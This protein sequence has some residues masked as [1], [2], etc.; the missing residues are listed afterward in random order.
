[1]KQYFQV[2]WVNGMKITSDHFIELENHFVCRLQNSLK[3]LVNEFSY[4]LVPSQELES[5]PPKFSI[6]LND[7]KI[8]SLRS[9]IMLSPDGDFIQI[10][11]NV[12]FKL[13]RPVEEATRY[14]LVI[15]GDP[16]SRMRIGQV[17]ELESPLRSPNS[18]PEYVFQFLSTQNNELHSLGHSIVPVGK[19][20]GGSFEEDISYIPPCT[21]VQSHPTLKRLGEDVKNRM[22]ELMRKVEELRKKSNVT[23]KEMLYEMVRFFNQNLTAI[24]WYSNSQPPVFLIEKVHQVAR[25]FHFAIITNNLQVKEEYAR[26]LKEFVDFQYNHLEIGSAVEIVRKFISNFQNFLPKDDTS[27]GV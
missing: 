16:Y 22:T 27:F 26:L 14:Y 18:I 15:T 13:V 19:Y 10:P 17:N 24:L 8:K 23:N 12:D 3:G 25:I 2:N 9:F 21:S 5:N 20:N 7:N 1:M 6:S 11:A 4:G